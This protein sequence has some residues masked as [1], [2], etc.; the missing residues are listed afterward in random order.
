MANGRLARAGRESK[1][2]P[3]STLFVMGLILVLVAA[4]APSRLLLT[5]TLRNGG[6]LVFAAPIEPDERF[7]LYYVHSVDQAAVWETHSI[8]ARGNIYVEEERCVMFGAGMGHRP[9]HG[10]L[11]ARDG[12]QVIEGIHELVNPFVLRVGS[13]GV[14][15]TITL[16]GQRI[17]LSSVIPGRAV[18]ISCEPV[19]LLGSVR[20][21]ATCNWRSTND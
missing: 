10:T 4:T 21:R 19:G 20:R 17:R 8:D 7:T 16:R 11:T 2:I 9:G 15:H 18:V 1:P 14:N 5:I 3:I 12:R 13:A 6:E